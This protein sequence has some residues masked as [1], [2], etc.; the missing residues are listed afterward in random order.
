MRTLAA[1]RA[2]QRNRPARDERPHIGRILAEEIVS[3][4]QCASGVPGATGNTGAAGATGTTGS[5]GVTGATGPTAGAHFGDPTV[6]P[7][8]TF[9]ALDL[10]GASQGSGPNLAGHTDV[11]PTTPP[12]A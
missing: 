5:P 12:R 7:L 8:S 10:L 4:L 6:D 2:G 3:P 1:S 9:T 11:P